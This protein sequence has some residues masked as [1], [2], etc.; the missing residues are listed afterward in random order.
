MNSE[1]EKDVRDEFDNSFD[2]PLSPEHAWRVLSDIRRIASSIPGVKLT[3]VVDDRTYQGTISVALGPAA[4]T[5]ASLVKLE[6]IDPV[7]HTARLQ[8]QGT[9]ASGRGAAHGTI[10]FRLEP[11]NGGSKVLVHTDLVL[12][13][14]AAE[15]GRRLET[16]HNT[17]AQVM[18]QFAN[19]LR[20]QVAGS[21]GP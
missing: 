4:L 7:N 10:S 11:S 12:S 21:A 8:A 2:V 13:G 1:T 20:E 16:V 5:F 18:S 6:E 15:Y 19:N 14:P 9:A 3:E 17:A